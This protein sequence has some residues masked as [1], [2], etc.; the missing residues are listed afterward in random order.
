MR[1]SLT[2]HMDASI[3]NLKHNRAVIAFFMLVCDF[4]FTP[5]GPDPPSMCHPITFRTVRN[6]RVQNVK[7]YFTTWARG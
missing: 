5:M 6:K 4:V 1:W 7:N 2:A 3:P